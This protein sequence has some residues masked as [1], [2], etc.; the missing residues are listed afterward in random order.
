MCVCVCFCYVCDVCVSV[1][2]CRAKLHVPVCGLH[3]GL[4]VLSWQCRRHG[5][6]SGGGGYRDAGHRCRRQCAGA[7]V[8]VCVKE[9]KE[10]VVCVCV[11]VRDRLLCARPH[12]ETALAVRLYRRM[13]TVVTCQ[14]PEQCCNTGVFPPPI[15]CSARARPL[16]PEQAGR[17]RVRVWQHVNELPRLTVCAGS[18]SV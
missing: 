12:S 16:S 15:G 13:S 17:V 5:G 2:L 11:C 10:N 9:H 1:S 14:H 6:G 7:R 4:G 3:V 18:L 8:S